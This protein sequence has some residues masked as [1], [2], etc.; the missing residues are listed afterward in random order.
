M[1][2]RNVVSLPERLHVLAIEVFHASGSGVWNNLPAALG[3]PNVTFNGFK[4]KL[5]TLLFILV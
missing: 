3:A 1:L 2:A 5:K 4:S